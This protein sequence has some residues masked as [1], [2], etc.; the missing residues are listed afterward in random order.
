MKPFVKTYQ[1]D[2]LRYIAMP[3]GGI[4]AG[5]ISINGAGNLIDP[6]I[7]NRPNRGADCGYTHFA[8]KVEKDGEFIDSR[9]L[10]GNEDLDLNGFG[11][12]APFRMKGRHFDSVTFHAAFP[13]A[14]V[15]LSDSRFP[16]TATIEAFNPFIPSN[17]RDSSIPAAFFNITLTNTAAEPLTFHLLQ[18]VSNLLTTKGLNRYSEKRGVKAITLNAA[19]R[20]RCF[21]NYGNITM[22]TDAAQTSHTTYWLRD[23]SFAHS[24]RM[25]MDDLCRAGDLQDRQYNEPIAKGFDTATLAARVDL[26]PGESRTLRF[27]IAWYVPTGEVYWHPTPVTRYKNYYATLFQSSDDVA[28]YCFANW[29]RLY[30]QTRQFADSLY[31]S[32]LP[33][34]MLDAISGNLA[35]LKST[36]NL[37]LEDGRLW[38]WEGVY[39]TVGSC[40]GSCQ[41]VYNYAYALAF[42]FPQLEKGLRNSEMERCLKPNGLMYFRMPITDTMYDMSGLPAFGRAC[43]DG[44]MGFVIKCYREWKL[45]G[46]T[47]WLRENWESIKSALAYAWSEE[48]PGKW[49]LQK[50]G[51]LSG[52]Q[53][54]T[55]DVDLFGTHAWLTGFYHVALEAAAEMA[56]FLGEAENARTYRAILTNGRRLLEE[57]CYNGEY[58]VQNL[59]STSLARIQKDGFYWDAERQECKVQPGEGCEIDQVLADWHADLNGLPPVFDPDKRKSALKAIYRHNF[60]SMHDCMNPMRA[61]ACNDERGV[62]M[63][64]WPKG[65]HKDRKPLPYSEECMTGFEYAYAGNL[66]QCGMEKQAVEVVRAVRQRYDGTR[67]NPFSEIEC[68]SSYTRAMA[69]YA[70]LPIY[71]GFQFDLPH[72]TLGFRPLKDGQYFW[73]VDGAWGTVVCAPAGWTFTLQYGS[74]E[75]T[76]FRS[77]LSTV[78][79]VTLNGEA[80][81]FVAENGTVHLNEK[82]LLSAGDRLVLNG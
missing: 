52:A 82:R 13:F 31:A 3:L 44:Q 45:S 22:A 5:N 42:L 6:E 14:T 4:G 25:Y 63:C 75:L 55:L 60:L 29:E 57:K 27:L 11:G 15:E 71:S 7:N 40:E 41:H 77:S 56:D 80:V 8:V 54:H 81:P 36:T 78:S 58:F 18:N 32:S 33:P 59:D 79:A 28:R 53:H 16:A 26:A 10:C 64:S 9:F 51:L 62:I 65:T 48:N 35:I 70:F 43:A 49:D 19:G 47:D 67:R 69:S 46:D 50:T 21:P 30:H 1:G 24:A 72:H 76:T 68:G 74:L 73:S 39:R 66:L 2:A 37:R 61:F 12:G 34:E 20:R 23:N 17:D 38:G